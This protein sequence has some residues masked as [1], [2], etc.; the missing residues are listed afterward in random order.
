MSKVLRMEGQR[1]VFPYILLW[2]RCSWALDDARKGGEFEYIYLYAMLLCAFTLE[3]FLNHLGRI[4]FPSNWKDFE[5]KRPIEKLDDV[6]SILNLD[7]S[8]GERPFQT[9]KQI[10]DFRNDLVHAKPAEVS[11]IVEFPFDEFLKP[12]KLPPDPLTNWEKSLSPDTA[13][14]YFEDTKEMIRILFVD[15]GL[16][17]DPFNEIY[18]RTSWKGIP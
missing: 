17:D 4:R 10:F 2:H 5:Y 9:F 12:D 18:S 8:K 15:A 11:A 3:A 1:K 14:M 13:E 7:I 16:G 6:S